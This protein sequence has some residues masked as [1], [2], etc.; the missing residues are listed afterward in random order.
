MFAMPFPITD[1]PIHHPKRH[2]FVHNFLLGSDHISILTTSLGFVQ[3]LN[4]FVKFRNKMYA[5]LLKNTLAVMRYNG[6][7]QKI[8]GHLLDCA[9][10][11]WGL[12]SQLHNAMH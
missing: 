5:Y 2:S 7:S 1:P 10:L 12:G 8:K 6:I 9:V 4:L 11:G 3:N